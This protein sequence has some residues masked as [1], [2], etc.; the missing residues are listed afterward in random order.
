MYRVWTVNPVHLEMF[1]SLLIP[2]ASPRIPSAGEIFSINFRRN[3]F[4]SVRSRRIIMYAALGYLALNLLLAI[5]FAGLAVSSWAETVFIQKK[6]GAAASGSS[7]R[8][9][10]QDMEALYEQATQE[11]KRVGAASA[12]ARRRFPVSEKLAALTRTLPNRT[13]VTG[14]LGSR[15]EQTLTIRAVYLVNPEKPYELPTKKWMEALKADSAFRQGL[16]RLELGN[17]SQKAKG[18]AELFSFE[19]V[20]EWEPAGGK[21]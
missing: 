1:R 2:T 13:W 10:K 20:A 17:S 19:L 21:I 8:I 4:I 6:F 11:L 18:E 14:I 15:N 3:E 12:V 5:G 16:K 9:L 7:E